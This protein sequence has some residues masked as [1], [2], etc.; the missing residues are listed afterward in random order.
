MTNSDRLDQLISE[1]KSGNCVAFVGAGFSAPAVRTWDQLLVNLADDDE[2]DEAVRVQVKAILKHAETEQ[3]PLF[4][5]EAAAELIERNLGD[6]FRPQVRGSLFWGGTKGLKKVNERLELLR[7]I[8]FDS[9]LTT[10]FDSSIPGKPLRDADL[11]ALLRNRSRGWV[12]AI[13]S[14]DDYDRSPVIT[15]HGDIDDYSEQAQ[16][17]VFSRSG[18]RRLLFET[19]NYQSLIRAVFATKTV[20]FLG[21]SFSDAYLNLIRSEVISMLHRENSRGIIAYAVMDD[22]NEAQV[23]YL[24]EYEGISAITYSTNKSNDHSGF[25]EILKK[26]SSGTK[27]GEVASRLLSG[28]KIMWFDPIREN[29]RVG[30]EILRNHMDAGN[31]IQESDLQ[32]AK[33]TLASD[34]IDLLISHWGHDLAVGPD[35]TRESNAHSLLRMVKI[36]NLAIPVLVF[37]SGDYADI[38]RSAALKFGA[39][40]YVDQF[41]D[42]FSR[43]ED[44]FGA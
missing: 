30:V 10:N 19:S 13:G 11:G 39:F 26:I 14:D 12:D 15:L 25:D 2:L 7:S 29:N 35:G 44:L 37:A 32:A 27:P 5:R 34:D 9:V 42:L 38:N 33:E 21:F 41:P 16:P 36:N 28:R 4:D 6:K 24:S 23:E 18:Y 43:I 22:V 17:L 20:V 1:I 3:Y 8:P 40:D 31:V